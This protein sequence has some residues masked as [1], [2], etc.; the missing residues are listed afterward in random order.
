MTPRSPRCRKLGFSHVWLT[1]VL[2]Q[3]TGTDYSDIGQPVDD[4]DLLKGIAGSPYAI[5]DYFD[6][7][8]DYAVDPKKRLAEFK[9]LLERLHEHQLKALID[10]VPNHVA[11][12]YHSDIKPEINF[13][14]NDDRSLFFDRAQQ[15]LLSP[16]GR[17]RSAAPKLPTCRMASP[18]SP[19]CKLAGMKCDGLFDGETWTSARSPATTS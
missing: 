6:V 14:T 9:A 19:T 4:P 3:A 13:G 10:F 5:K 11:R 17:G 1:G 18:I 12:C 16:A 8:P 15:L 7:C 2:Q